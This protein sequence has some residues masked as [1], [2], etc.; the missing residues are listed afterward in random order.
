MRAAKSLSLLLG[1]A[2][3]AAVA[4]TP[5]DDHQ[6]GLDALR[7]GDVRNAISLLRAPA[8]SGYGPSQVLLGEILDMSEQNEEAVK[9]FRLAADQGLAGGLYGLGAMHAS[10]EGVTR[11]VEAARQWMTKAAHA[12][13][14]QAAIVLASAYMHGGLGLNAEERASPEALAWIERG[15]ALDSVAAIDR[16]A[17]AYRQGQLGLAADAK[18]AEEL[19]ARSR[20][21]R[22]IVA[23]K[24]GKK[25]V[26]KPNG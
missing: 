15:A 26:V 11:D 22:K 23:P 4:A 5:L 6:A 14:K 21:L 10:G 19:E 2:M 24:A 13:H 12:G 17:V 1:L 18:K 3:T 16:L 20:T 25:K 8:D 7:K 9:Y